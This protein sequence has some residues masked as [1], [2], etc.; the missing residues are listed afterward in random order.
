MMRIEKDLERA[1]RFSAS[2]KNAINT[3]RSS[4]DEFKSDVVNIAVMQPQSKISEHVKSVGVPIA[5]ASVHV[6]VLASTIT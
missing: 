1:R 4:H 6:L 5:V 3:G 2:H